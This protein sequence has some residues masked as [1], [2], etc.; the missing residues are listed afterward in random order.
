M[1]DNSESLL[2]LRSK[3]KHIEIPATRFSCI[4]SGSLRPKLGLGILFV[5]IVITLG[6]VL[7]GNQAPKIAALTTMEKKV[8]LEEIAKANGQFGGKAYPL[9]VKDKDGENII[10]SSFSLSSVMAMLYLGAKGASKEQIKTALAF[11]ENE[12]ILLEGFQAIGQ[13]FAANDNVT[14]ATANR[15]Y[16]QNG[17]DLMAEYQEKAKSYFRAEAE[18]VDFAQSEAARKIVN[19][20]VE[21]QTNNKIK[22]LIPSGAVDAL[23]RLVLVN[24]IYF[25]GNW[26]DKFDPKNT[27]KAKFTKINGDKVEVDMMFKRADFNI[28]F[29]KD[30][31]FHVMEMPYK[32]NQLSMM[33]FLP[34]KPEHFG[35]MEQQF[36]NLNLTSLK[37]DKIKLEV[38]IPKFKF[39]SNF[40]LNEALQSLGAADIFDQGKADFS[41]LTSKNDLF[42]SSVFQKAFIEVNEEGTE[43]AAASGAVMMLRA[44]PQ[45]M[46]FR[47]DRPFMFAIRDNVSGL[48]LFSGRVMDPTVE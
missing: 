16:V 46:P 30:L 7:V 48:I 38:W 25:K 41:A 19:D 39:S 44:M 1:I 28:T 40:K 31:D 29:S 5:V 27:K 14:L 13:D 2:N 17:Y 33:F 32:G 6:V 26:A 20:W 43:A 18:N 11:P 22:D 21:Q 15:L 23:T 4:T 8:V 35:K 36:A 47:C 10:S 12:Q 24:A 34:K 42:V 45:T 37:F 9:M 3:C